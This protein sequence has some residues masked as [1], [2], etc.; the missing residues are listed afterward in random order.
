MTTVPRETTP[1]PE[2]ALLFGDRLPLVVAFAELLSG[3]GVERGLLGPREAPRLW[4]RHLLNCAAIA[5]SIPVGASVAD[6]GSGAGLPGVVLAILRPDLRITAIEPLLRRSRFLTEVAEELPLPNLL[7]LR[8][9]AEDAPRLLRAETGSDEWPPG[10]HGTLPAD[11]APERPTDRVTHTRFDVVTARAVAPL[12]RLAGWCLPL[13]RPGGQLL[14]MKGQQAQQELDRAERRLVELGAV[15]WGVRRQDGSSVTPGGDPTG[16][17]LDPPTVVV[18]VQ[19]GPRTVST[20]SGRL[21]PR[22]RSPR[23]RPGRPG[24]RPGRRPGDGRSR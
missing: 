21:A 5:E 2:A 9:R 18:V 10:S 17:R 15:R 19:Q 1:P 12:E 4:D 6:V 22:R 3:P 20:G 11:R 13:V 16:V 7:V 8:A 14:A 23:A 24:R